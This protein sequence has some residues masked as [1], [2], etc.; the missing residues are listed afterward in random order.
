MALERTRTDPPYR[1]GLEAHKRHR[2]ASHEEE[3][4]TYLRA[5][6]VSHLEMEPDREESQ[7]QARGDEVGD[8]Q[9]AVGPKRESA[10]PGIGGVHEW[11]P[12]DPDHEVVL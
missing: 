9:E 4:W 12:A 5:A 10:R 6:P 1:V 2:R 8:L 11:A 7:Q 3:A